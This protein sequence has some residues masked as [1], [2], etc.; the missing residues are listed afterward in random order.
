MSVKHTYCTAEGECTEF[1]F[2]FDDLAYYLGVKSR[3]A[4]G[5]GH[6]YNSVKINGKWFF[7][8]PQDNNCT[9][10]TEDLGRFSVDSVSSGSN[11]KDYMIFNHKEKIDKSTSN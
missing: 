9:F 7:L 11:N 3:L 1:V 2:F 4:G 6:I 10:Y 8:E 5:E